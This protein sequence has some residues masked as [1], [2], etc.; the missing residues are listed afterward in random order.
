MSTQTF[1]IPQQMALFQ[2]EAPVGHFAGTNNPRELRALALLLAGSILREAL[3][4]SVGC[5]NGPD[6]IHR[7]SKKK[8]L[9]IGRARLDCIDRYGRR[10]RPGVYW[11]TD[12]DRSLVLKWLERTGWSVENLT[13][14]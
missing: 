6:L 8:G 1:R 3:D 2:N 9:A 12:N 4:K 11:L 7:L 13:V 5:S 14:H 10:C